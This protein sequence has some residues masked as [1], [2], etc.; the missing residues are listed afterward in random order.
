VLETG[1]LEIATDQNVHF[2]AGN[3]HQSIGWPYKKV[4]LLDM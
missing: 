4:S 3:R 2:V 1:L